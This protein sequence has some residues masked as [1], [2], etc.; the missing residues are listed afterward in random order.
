MA[1]D[2]VRCLSCTGPSTSR[3]SPP[4]SSMPTLTS[5]SLI[6]VAGFHVLLLLMILLVLSLCTG[7]FLVSSFSFTAFCLSVCF[8]IFNFFFY[9]QEIKGMG[10]CTGIWMAR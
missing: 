4:D 3:E 2:G 1:V 7:F 10:S 5:F 8:E 9:F 6:T